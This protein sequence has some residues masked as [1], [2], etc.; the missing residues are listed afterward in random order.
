V[1][2]LNQA[3]ANNQFCLYYQ[4]IAP[5]TTKL[6]LGEHYEVLL[7]LV[8]ETGEVISP[9]AF[10]PAAE[11][12]NF[13]PAIDRWVLSTFFKRFSATSGARNL[14]IQPSLYAINLS[15]ASVND[16]Q[17]IDFL[18]QQFELHQIPPEQ[19]C[20]EITE[21]VAITNLTKAALFIRELKAMGCCFALDDFGSGMSS[22]AYLKYLPVDYLKIDG[23][24]IKDIVN[25]PIAT[26][27]VEAINRIGHVMGIQTIAEFVSNE[28]ILDKV[29]A[30]GVD[31]AQGYAIA[32][33]QPI[34]ALPQLILD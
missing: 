15:G 5:L 11:R 17:F 2:R 14:N 29:K 6:A 21:T 30:I 3:L 27:M 8:D 9:V 23:C 25:D 12:Y 1:E 24:F 7:R 4:T 10:L 16:E 13:M 22:F 19:I 18:K 28:T 34:L 26:S 33:P 20:F 31:Y 32:L